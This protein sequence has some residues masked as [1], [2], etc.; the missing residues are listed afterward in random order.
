MATGNN[1]GYHC[2]ASCRKTES[3]GKKIVKVSYLPEL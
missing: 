2:F 1:L 3:L